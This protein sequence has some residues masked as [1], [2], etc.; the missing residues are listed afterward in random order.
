MNEQAVQTRAG[1]RDA[2]HT[3]RNAPDFAMPPALHR[4]LAVTGLMDEEHVAKFDNAS[5]SI[6]EGVGAVFRDP[7]ALE[8]RKRAGADVRGE[9][10]H[11]DRALVRQLISTIPSGWTYRARNPEKSLPFGG[12]NSI[13]VSM[14]GAR[15]NMPRDLSTITRSSKLDEALRDYVERRQREISV[16]DELNTHC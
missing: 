6:L 7:I 11:L 14:T 2:R 1:G 4:K 10:I 3:L 5:K 12:K 13:F 8:D 15:C 9:R 16:V